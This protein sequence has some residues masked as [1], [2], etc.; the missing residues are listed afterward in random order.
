MRER[1]P[2]LHLVKEHFFAKFINA[3]ASKVI[4]QRFLGPIRAHIYLI[5]SN[6]RCGLIFAVEFNV[7]AIRRLL[8]LNPFLKLGRC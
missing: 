7:T 4:F 5:A 1:L 8:A 3:K 2:S 6:L